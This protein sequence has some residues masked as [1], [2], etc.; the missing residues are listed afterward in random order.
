MYT[1]PPVNPHFN[2]RRGPV[3]RNHT[4]NHH[5][6]TIFMIEQKLCPYGFRAGAKVSGLV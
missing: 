2:D 3:N 5:S 1:N 4:D 6:C